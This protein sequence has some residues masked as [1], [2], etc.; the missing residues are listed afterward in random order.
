[1]GLRL[2]NAAYVVH[3]K[4]PLLQV[5]IEGRKAVLMSDNQ[6]PTIYQAG[7][8]SIGEEFTDLGIVPEVTIT[9]KG[10]GPTT[11][12]GFSNDHRLFAL[13]TQFLKAINDPRPG[14]FRE[15]PVSIPD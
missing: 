9:P 11:L 6:K 3:E 15:G 7:L 5:E 1:M 2:A 13:Y 8:V 12:R 10:G 14:S 4:Y